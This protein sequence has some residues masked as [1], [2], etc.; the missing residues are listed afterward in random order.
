MPWIIDVRCPTCATLAN[1][2]DQVA[3]VFGVTRSGKPRKQCN[4]CF[5]AGLE[6]DLANVK[7]V[8]SAECVFCGKSVD[9]ILDIRSDFGFVKKTTTPRESCRNCRT[10]GN[11]NASLNNLVDDVELS[12]YRTRGRYTRPPFAVT[13]DTWNYKEAFKEIGG[14]F[15]REVE[16]SDGPGWLFPN[17]R[18]G[19]VITILQKSEIEKDDNEEIALNCKACQS[20]V[21]EDYG[22]YFICTACG[23]LQHKEF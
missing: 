16:G 5:E 11:P 7:R 19:A 10:T 6:Y 1:D 22:L 4:E 20:S 21:I 15:V 8:V 18:Q 13:G 17:K 9:N 23:N 3:S 2:L 12:S 14:K